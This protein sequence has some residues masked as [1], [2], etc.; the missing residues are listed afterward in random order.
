MEQKSPD[1]RWGVEQRL[2]FIEFRLYW[3]GGVNRADITKR[4]G[5][6]VPQ[7]S[8]DLSRYQMLAPTNIV[9]DRSKKRYMRGEKFS[10]RFLQP[11]ADRYLSQLRSIAE[12]GRPL[13]ETWL[14]EAPA[15]DALRVP[16]RHVQDGVLRAVLE[17]IRKRKSLEIHYQSLT[18]TR[19]KPSWFWISPHA[20]AFDGNRWHVR[21]YKHQ[22]QQFADFL[23]PRFLDVRG[24]KEAGAEPETDS[25]WNEVVSVDLKPH[26]KL[27][28]EQK[29][30]VALDFGMKAGRLSMPVRLALLYY[31]LWRLHLDFDA[32]ERPPYE[33]H[34]VLANPAR[35][36]QLLERAR[37]T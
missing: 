19:P 17:A 22:D 32:E 15:T 16:G 5:V 24:M 10:P 1:L 37:L 2:E 3:E 31:F 18:P 13:N 26:P 8:Q 34:I 4:F 25:I 7:A 6:S 29:R 9:Y 36:R 23:L 27:N 28:D 12:G 11:D 14:S 35:I 33:Q 20:L 30:I 21:A